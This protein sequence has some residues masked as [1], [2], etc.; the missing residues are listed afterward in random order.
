M[1]EAN[2]GYNLIHYSKQQRHSLNTNAHGSGIPDAADKRLRNDGLMSSPIS[3]RIYFYIQKAGAKMPKPEAGLGSYVHQVDPSSL[4]LY[5]PANV[6]D[7]EK[8]KIREKSAEIRQE[9]GVSA[10]SSYELAVEFFGY[11]GYVSHEMGMAVVFGFGKDVPV[12]YIG[13]KDQ[14]GY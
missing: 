11:D 7:D 8:T 5:D 1:F 13:T 9:T 6:S 4:N 12:E 3:K 14:F 10:G 2:S